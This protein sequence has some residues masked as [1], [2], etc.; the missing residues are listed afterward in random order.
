MKDW[1][2]DLLAAWAGWLAYAGLHTGP[3]DWDNCLSAS[4][5]AMLLSIATST[6]IKEPK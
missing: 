3:W 4:A 1:F 6:R 2:E 5:A